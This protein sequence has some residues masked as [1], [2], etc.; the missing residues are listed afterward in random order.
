MATNV[1]A[2]DRVGRT[3]RGK[4]QLDA[5]IGVGGMAAVYAATHRNGGRAAVKVL[6]PELAAMREIRSR[7]VR[8]GYLANRVGHPAVVR[9]IDDDSD[10]DG[11]PFLVMELVEGE[12]LAQR[13]ESESLCAEELLAVAEQVLPA[14]VAGHCRGVIHQDLKPENLLVDG[15]GRVRLLDYGIARTVDEGDSDVLKI[16]ATGTPSFMS[17]EQVH[18]GDEIGPLSDIYSFGATLFA[19]AAGRPPHV[20]NTAMHL[21][22]KITSERPPRVCSLAPDLPEELGAFIDRCLAREPVQRWPS[23][24]AML[25]EVRR[26][27]DLLELAS[28]PLVLACRHGATQPDAPFSDT[29]GSV[30]AMVVSTPRVVDR[31]GARELPTSPPPK[32]RRP[33]VAIA[34]VAAA[35]VG[36][37]VGRSRQQPAPR[38]AA[39][40]HVAEPA[41]ELAPVAPPKPTIVVSI[42]T[43]QI[44]APPPPVEPSVTAPTAPVKKK[45]KPADAPPPKLA[46]YKESPY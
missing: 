21:L 20:A 15:D 35:T 11:M 31:S 7:F 45:S 29:T 36:L 30:R 18:G 41:R 19:L 3:I 4:W 17:P 32:S 22:V 24:E 9:A 13:G 34:I 27:R 8:E 2:A 40:V 46:D 37:V 38:A 33:W 26:L 25:A 42:V 14:L 1:S 12:T 44:P 23:A 39:A 28:S 16:R 10:E 6:H 43:V 5:L